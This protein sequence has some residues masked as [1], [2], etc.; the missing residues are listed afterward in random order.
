[1]SLSLLAAALVAA[2]P[3]PRAAPPGPPPPPRT[4]GRARP[5]RLE[6]GWVSENDYPPAALRAGAEGR[7]TVRYVIGRDGDV[8]GCEVVESSGNA[9]LDAVSCRIVTDRFVFDP[10][11]DREGRR[12]AETRRQRFLWRLPAP[13]PDAEPAPP[14]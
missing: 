9:D 14:R 8:E 11:R 10:A 6:A 2:Q 3:A 12:I 7:V 13:P 4:A 5:A 1:M